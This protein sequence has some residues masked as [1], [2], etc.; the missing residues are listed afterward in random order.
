L[1]VGLTLLQAQ[2]SNRTSGGNASIGMQGFL[3][4]SE[5][6]TAVY[7]ESHTPKSNSNG[8]ICIEFGTGIIANGDFAGINRANGPYFIKTETDLA[9]GTNYTIT[10][11]SQL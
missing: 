10:S 11:V 4:G 8:L 2:T 1:V 7:V 5:C 3:Q 9:E 6:G